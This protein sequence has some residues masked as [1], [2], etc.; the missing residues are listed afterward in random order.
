[1]TSISFKTKQE[2]QPVFKRSVLSRAIS[3][4]LTPIV[5][6]TTPALAEEQ[7]ELT[8]EELV[9]T[10]TRRETS[11]QDIPINISALSGEALSEVGAVDIA[12]L[13]KI[14]PGLSVTDAGARTGFISNGVVIR[15]LNGLDTSL[16]HSPVKT[17]S[18]VAI[19]LN[20]T[21]VY[22]NIQ[23]TDIERVEV[24]R[25]PQG[26]LYGSGSVG[27]TVRYIMAEPSTSGFASKASLGVSKTGGASDLNSSAEM[28]LNMPVSDSFALRFNVKN[29]KEA[30]FIDHNNIYALDSAG[31]PVLE[32][33]SDLVNSPAIR[34]NVEDA[35]DSDSLFV[36]LSG[37]WQMSDAAE[38]KL[39]YFHQ[40]N[41]M[42]AT[43]NESLALGEGS[44][45]SPK[46]ILEPFSGE[47]D[48]LSAELSFDLGFADVTSVTS[49]YKTENQGTFDLT[50]QYLGF[51]FYP[52]YYGASPRPLIVDNSVREEDA[53][54][55]EIRVVSNTDGAIDWM[56]GLFYMK[57][58]GDTKTEQFFPGYNDY[59]NAC[60]GAGLPFGGEPCG[61][62]TYFGDPSVVGTAAAVED[63]AYLTNFQDEFEDK[64]IFGEVTWH[65]TDQL[66]L[67]AGIR[68]FDQ[69][70]TLA[71]QGGL[72]FANL[73]SNE[74]GSFDTSDELYK[75]NASYRYSEDHQ[76]YFTYSEGFRRGGANAL[77]PLGSDDISSFVPDTLDNTELGV[78]GSFGGRVDYTASYFSADWND[79]QTRASCTDLALICTVNAGDA[80]VSGFDFELNAQLT[81]NLQARL[82]YTN[83]DTELVRGNDSGGV[84][85]ATGSELA[86]APSD[87]GNITLIYNRL[88]TGNKELGGYI[89]LSY[90]SDRAG[91]L[92]NL[93]V[94]EL[95][96]LDGY[97]L[98]DGAVSLRYNKW[99]TKLFVNNILDDDTWV[100]QAD[101]SLWQT[102][103]YAGAQRPRTIGFSVTYEY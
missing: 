37:L 47:T 7:S 93:G 12:D 56:A 69:E 15:G 71:E 58:D 52:D 101:A 39:D 65:V 100:S 20:E 98:V 18:P 75:F 85:F 83:L 5:V 82:G 48:M 81:E 66:D 88:L 62:G 91:N 42:D 103:S 57:Q 30:G 1:M 84:N 80:E 10:A 72:A 63:L 59:A 2:Q 21:P 33:P 31:K 46:L 55:Q 32:D 19:Y 13:G 102:G 45:Q 36:R 35:D 73:L 89:N 61:F 97:T 99:L 28:M 95:V 64:A 87:S 60:F 79:I 43:S 8:M 54:I 77:G 86:G 50:G 51:S 4:A 44:R 92:P 23:F 94:E 76:V 38:L 41:D 90:T 49:A 29:V 14:I 74:R 17:V 40:E 53:F 26:T 27:G 67:T 34:R 25:G 16:Q 70:Y 9:I 78:K 3:I 96:K 22:T 68:A 24:L 11:I 6:L